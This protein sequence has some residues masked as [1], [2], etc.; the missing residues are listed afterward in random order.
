MAAAASCATAA[1]LVIQAS[2]TVGQRPSVQ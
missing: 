2:L 1:G